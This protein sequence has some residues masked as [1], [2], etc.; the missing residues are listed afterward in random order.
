MIENMICVGAGI[1]PAEIHCKSRNGELKET[2]QIIMYFAK[3]MTT[4]TW[5]QIAGY[6]ELDHA[7]AM[8]SYKT[9]QNLIDTDRTFREKIK[10]HEMRLKVI[11]IDRMVEVANDTF[12]PLEFEV[13]KLE[14]K[15]CKLRE[16]VEVIKEE[17]QT[18]R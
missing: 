9:V 18:V 14:N 3:K 7:T 6:F 16:M 11:K 13:L 17:L 8:H 15:I 1:T 4:K 5:A 10:R 12:K 2:R